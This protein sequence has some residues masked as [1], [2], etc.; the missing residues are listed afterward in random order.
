MRDPGDTAEWDM[1]DVDGDQT[2]FHG[3]TFGTLLKILQSGGMKAGPNGHS[4]N[5]KYYTGV[6]G[7]KFVG[8]AI[9]RAD[10]SKDFDIVPSDQ[11][12]PQIFFFGEAPLVPRAWG[13]PVVVECRSSKLVKYNARNKDLYVTPGE[14]EEMLSIV[15]V[16]RVHVRWPW[17]Q[18]YWQL[19]LIHI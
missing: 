12:K 7:C 4:H 6:F 3:T 18:N 13:C 16:V 1:V 8:D 10:P 9:H 14:P 5:G 17:V 2:Y 19:S 11:A 15:R